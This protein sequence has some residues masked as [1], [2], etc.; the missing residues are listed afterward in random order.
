M[1]FY[2]KLVLTVLV[3]VTASEFI[4]SA[5]NALLIL[6]LLGIIL[7]HFGAFDTLVNQL[8]LKR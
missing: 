8:T 1:P 6:I 7:G 2:A 5:V 3:V 4:P